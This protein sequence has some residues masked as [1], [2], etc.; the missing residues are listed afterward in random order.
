VNKNAFFVG[1]MLDCKIFEGEAISDEQPP[2]FPEHK[3]RKLG[4]AL[5]S[6]SLSL[7][8]FHSHQDTLVENAID[9]TVFM[10]MRINGSLLH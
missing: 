8:P 6:L 7:P 4:E 10:I 1:R 2:H 5:C 9:T 3:I